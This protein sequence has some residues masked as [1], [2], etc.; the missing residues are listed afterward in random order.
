MMKPDPAL[1]RYYNSGTCLGVIGTIPT[2]QDGAYSYLPS[3]SEGEDGPWIR[4]EDLHP[5]CEAAEKAAPA[6][7]YRTENQHADD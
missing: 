4:T 5:T 1:Y 3:H 2:H 7:F 6:R